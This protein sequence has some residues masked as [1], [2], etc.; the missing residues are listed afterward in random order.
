MNDAPTPESADPSLH[1]PAA[2]D[3]LD[4]DPNSRISAIPNRP[5]AIVGT[6]AALT[7]LLAGALALAGLFWVTKLMDPTIDGTFGKPPVYGQYEPTISWLGATVVPTALLLIAFTI[8]FLAKRWLPEWL[9]VSI[10]VLLA[11]LLAASIA[12][13][14]GDVGDLVRRISNSGKWLSYASDVPLVWEHGVRGFAEM[15]P[16][17]GSEFAY[18]NTRTHPPGPVLVLFGIFKVLGATHSLRI[19]T[20]V[21]TLGMT[22]AVG[23]LLL[24]RSMGGERAGRIGAALLVAAPGPLLLAYT[25]MDLV[26]AAGMSIAAG[27]LVLSTKRSSLWWAVGGGAVLGL[28][29]LMT[30]ATIFIAAA[31]TVAFLVAEDNL[32]RAM[33]KLGAA[34][35][36]GLVIL[37]SATLGLGFDL[38]GSYLAVPSRTSLYNPYWAIGGP[39]AWLVFAGLPIAVLGT[40][41]LFR[42]SG[43]G[44][45]PVFAIALVV[46]MLIWA[47]LPTEITK[48]RAGEL[49]RTMAFLYPVLAAVAAPVV[50][51]WVRQSGRLRHAIVPSLMAL[52]IAQA[53]VIQ[54][55]WDTLF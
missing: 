27:L 21:A 41:G 40:W 30:F 14:R 2:A 47:V 35:V 42:R 39:G 3:Q 20:T 55:L 28:T 37:A 13:V 12:V 53:V 54:I 44:S 48:L 34:A 43:D 32:G 52:S 36:G 50:D 24:G 7:A 31:A 19:A 11:V 8:V 45:R 15:H 16:T 51:I 38:I 23:A 5:T 22:T 10:L 46:I 26:F 33:T 4:R 49:E 25:S 9:S 17:L 1:G 29:T 18:W 6:T